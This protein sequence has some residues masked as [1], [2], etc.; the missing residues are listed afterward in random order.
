MADAL[1]SLRQAAHGK[2]PVPARPARGKGP[3]PASSLPGP[4]PRRP[5]TS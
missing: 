4:A 2:E 1:A 3:R 5:W